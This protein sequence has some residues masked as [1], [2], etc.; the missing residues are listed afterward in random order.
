MDWGDGTIEKNTSVHYY[1]RSGVY[2]LRIKGYIHY[3]E[4]NEDSHLFEHTSSASCKAVLYGNGFNTNIPIF[5]NSM[6]L[7]KIDPNFF[8]YRSDFTSLRY[9]FSGCRA[10]TEIPQGLLDP[11]VNLEDATCLFRYVGPVAG[12]DYTIIDVPHD[13]L[14]KCTKLVSVERIFESS[15]I[16]TIPPDLFK[17]LTNLTNVKW[18]FSGTKITSIPSE[19]FEDNVALSDISSCF[20]E[21][22]K[23]TSIPKDLFSKSNSATNVNG[24]FE[25]TGITTVPSGLF[26]NCIEL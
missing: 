20:A 25:H 1:K 26:D 2:M 15:I 21:C 22:W 10:L 18:A 8:Q 17:G 3:T 5:Q 16:D 13:L 4:V 19:L 12:D 11:L 7:E 6:L 23:L 9:F 24:T 14:S